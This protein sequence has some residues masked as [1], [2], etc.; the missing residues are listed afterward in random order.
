MLKYSIKMNIRFALSLI[1]VACYNHDFLLAHLFVLQTTAS[2][3]ESTIKLQR[4]KD[5]QMGKKKIMIIAS[6]EN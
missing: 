2:T 1:L 4:D 5:K 6:Y 3:I